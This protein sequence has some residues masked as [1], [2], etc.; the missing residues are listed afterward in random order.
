MLLC[1]VL[2]RSPKRPKRLYEGASGN[3]LIRIR[4]PKEGLEATGAA[5]A[6]K[7]D[8]SRLLRGY[9]NTAAL[10]PTET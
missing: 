8:L 6:G 10:G 4:R 9:G 7:T 5:P 1:A 3:L 2:S